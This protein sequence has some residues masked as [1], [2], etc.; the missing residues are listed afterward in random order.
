MKNKFSL[1][2]FSL[3]L[4]FLLGSFAQ[5][6]ACSPSFTTSSFCEM[7]GDADVI[8][9][10]K[11]IGAKKQRVTE[12]NGVKE[13]W[14]VGEIYFEVQESFV[15]IRKGIRVTVSSGDENG[16]CGTWFKHNESYLIYGYGSL[17]KGFVDGQRTNLVS[18]AQE[19]LEALRNLPKRGT[20]SRIFGTIPQ[21]AKSSL[22]SDT[23][24]P[25]SNLMLKIQQLQG[26]KQIFETVTDSFGNYEIANVPAGK[27]KI[28]PNLSN[29][30]DFQ[31]PSVEVNDRGCVSKDFLIRNKTKI[32][33]K[34]LDVE[35]KPV[36]EIFVE[37]I[38]A[39]LNKKPRPFALQ[40]DDLTNEGGHFTIENI[41]PGNYVLSVNYTG[42][43]DEED[44]F[45]TTF[46]PTASEIS[47]AQ[48]FH[49]EFGSEDI[50]NLIFKL[51]PRLETQE[52]KG[53]VVWSDGNPAFD[54]H[55]GL[56]DE[57]TNFYTSDMRSDKNGNF[58]LTGI[59]GREYYISANNY[60]SDKDANLVSY[61]ASDKFILDNDVKL[62]RLVLEKKEK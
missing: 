19:D 17:K 18:E 54:V 48:I 38:P 11:A 43:P 55:I 62:F 60:S 6:S 29:I 41:P 49:I 23:F 12:N 53:T 4:M 44:A 51:P 2:I 32:S 52:I 30:F 33:G 50:K 20:G 5:V 27:Y 61:T 26:K 13:T 45:P 57:E 28:L 58:I 1:L 37:L 25:M 31:N 3:V 56:R 21:N 7:V 34:V 16:Y 35:G 15:G 22:L 39:E 42:S 24:Q 10:G 47:Q 40:E 36:K 14:D 46:Y 8:F 9:V 59:L